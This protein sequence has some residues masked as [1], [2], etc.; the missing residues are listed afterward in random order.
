M[1]IMRSV[2]GARIDVFVVPDGCDVRSRCWL[3]SMFQGWTCADAV[4]SV[5]DQFARDFEAGR[6]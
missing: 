6:V 3:V 4:G 2:G 5:V 1:S